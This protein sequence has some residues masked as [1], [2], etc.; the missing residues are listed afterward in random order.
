MF[1]NLLQVSLSLLHF[2]WHKVMVSQSEGNEVNIVSSAVFTYM[3]Q[4][5]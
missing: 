3:L 4:P 5:G 1:H 2:S